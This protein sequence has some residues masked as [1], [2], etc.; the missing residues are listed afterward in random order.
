MALSVCGATVIQDLQQHLQRGG[1]GEPPGGGG[2]NVRGHDSAVFLGEPSVHKSLQCER[3]EHVF[4]SKS[5]AHA[6]LEG[7][8][9]CTCACVCV[10]ARTHAHTHTHTRKQGRSKQTHMHAYKHVHT[11]KNRRSEL[12][13]SN[14]PAAPIYALNA[15]SDWE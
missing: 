1:S 7:V 12:E 13:E 15:V 14:S 9:M 8:H 5:D 11:L 4:T 6:V 2:G 10:C 3:S